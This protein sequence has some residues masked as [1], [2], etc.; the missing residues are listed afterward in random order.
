MTRRNSA[1]H[2]AGNVNMQDRWKGTPLR[3]TGPQDLQVV[4]LKTHP[5]M[6]HE[7]RPTAFHTDLSILEPPKDAVLGKFS[8]VIEILIDQNADL[9]LEELGAQ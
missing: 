1:H 6:N 7:M 3:A 8:A 2:L 4:R 5:E 9:N